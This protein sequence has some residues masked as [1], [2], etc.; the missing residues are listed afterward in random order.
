MRRIV[1]AVLPARMGTSFRWLVASTWV[2]NLGDG[3]G[4]AAGPLLIASQTKDP[5]LVALAALLQRLPWLLFG[6]WAGLLADRLDRRRLVA[7]VDLLRAGILAV[8]A[9]TIVSGV[10]GSGVILGAM[11]LLG[12][13]EVFADTASQTLLPMVVGR[14]DLAIGNAR[15]MAG[16]LTAN[17]LG[18]PA[19]GAALFA[20]AT[21]SPFV[22][23]AAC[24]ALGALLV[25]RVRVTAVER[26]A[27]PAHVGRDIR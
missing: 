6:L 5:V 3:I 15:L 26:P 23:Q 14:A 1:E 10:A 18:G 11:F 25:A 24:V 19:L 17:Q 7:G 21:A 27:G 2:G 4:L 8:L 9:A 16:F 12:T 22:T 13:A 20:A